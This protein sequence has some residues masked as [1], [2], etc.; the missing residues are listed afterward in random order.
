MLKVDPPTRLRFP[1]KITTTQQ[2]NNATSK[3][4]LAERVPRSR[5]RRAPV[6]NTR[7]HF[8]ANLLCAFDDFCHDFPFRKQIRS[9]VRSTVSAAF[10]VC[11]NACIVQRI[12]KLKTHLFCSSRR[13][14]NESSQLVK[15]R[16]N[17]QTNNSVMR[18]SFAD[19][20][21]A[22]ATH[23]TSSSSTTPLSRSSSSNS[24]SLSAS[25][26]RWRQII[27]SHILS[28]PDASLS[29]DWSTLLLLCSRR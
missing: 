9:S 27:W 3:R 7:R 18:V 11:S 16:N 4:R 10:V 17:L 28:P 20:S 19:A 15:Q 13:I 29:L 23:V 5:R 8:P 26:V 25:Q 1:C 24:T 21:N 14:S 2:H 12:R 22:Q 6:R